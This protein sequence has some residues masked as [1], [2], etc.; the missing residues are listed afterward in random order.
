MLTGVTAGLVCELRE[1]LRGIGTLRGRDGERGRRLS[2]RESTS[3]P[4]LIQEPA[5]PEQSAELEYVEKQ[6]VSHVVPFPS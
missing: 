1:G 4:Y 6:V 5:A 2:R 3:W